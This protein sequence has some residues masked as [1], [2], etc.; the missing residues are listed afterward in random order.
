MK[1]VLYTLAFLLS[2]HIIH[3]QD[4]AL[5]N[6]DGKAI[7]YIATDDE[8]M[9]VFLYNGKPVAY[10]TKDNVYGYNG[11]HLGWYDKGVIR[12]HE[13]KIIATTKD[14]S[15]QYTQ[16][17]PYKNYKQSKPY[18]SYQHTAPYK[19]YAQS[20]WTA[21]GFEAFLLKGQKER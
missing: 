18:K 8:E 14:A 2:G 17:E 7:A 16:Y 12:T 21:E 4:I 15:S 20:G 10:I 19:V 11:K 5:F 9:P 6:K 13:G 1:Q 3:A